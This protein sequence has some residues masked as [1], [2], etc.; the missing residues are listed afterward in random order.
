MFDIIVLKILN[1]CFSVFV[2]TIEFIGMSNL[3]PRFN[4]KKGKLAWDA[5]LQY[6]F[7]KAKAKN[8]SVPKLYL[9][10]A[11]IW[12]IVLASPIL[13]DLN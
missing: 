7:K 8:M 5:K 6:R 13:H 4:K 9:A 12:V 1:G 11:W 2:S 3:T 10:G